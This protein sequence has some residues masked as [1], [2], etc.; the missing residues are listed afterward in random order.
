VCCR[1]V[2]PPLVGASGRR[3]RIRPLVTRHRNAIIILYKFKHCRS[4]YRKLLVTEK[5]RFVFTTGLLRQKLM[6]ALSPS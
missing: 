4:Y 3:D 2:T 5:T 1:A 6:S